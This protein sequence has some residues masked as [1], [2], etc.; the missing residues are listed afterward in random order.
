MGNEGVLA[1]IGTCEGSCE[2]TV[3]ETWKVIKGYIHGYHIGFY[4][5]AV[6]MEAYIHGVV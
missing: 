4:C 2:P 1:S 5:E 3:G 6:E